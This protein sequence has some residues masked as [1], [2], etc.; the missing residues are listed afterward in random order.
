MKRAT[1][2]TGR[3]LPILTTVALGAFALLLP[4][5]VAAQNTPV[6]GSQNTVTADPPVAHPDEK[7][8]VVQL[9]SGLQFADFNAKTYNYTPP[10]GCSGPWDKVIFKA[11]FS[12]TAGVQYDRTAEVFLGH[13]NIYYGTTAEPG[14]TLAPSWHIERDVTDYSA[15]FKTSQTGEVDLGNLVNSTYTGVISGSATLEF[16]KSKRDHDKDTDDAHRTADALYPLPNGPGGAKGLASSADELAETFT[17][18]TNVERAYLDVITQ[19]Q[20]NDEFWY[21]CAPNDVAGELEDCGN[22]PF[23]EAEISVD[24]QPAGVAPVYPWIYTG[25]IDPF[26]WFP[27]P[28]VQTLNFKPYRVDLTPFAGLLSNGQPHT[29]AVSV[30]NANNYFNATATLL[31]FRDPGEAKITGAVTANTIGAAPVPVITESL[32]TDSSGDITGSV[33]VTSHREFRVSGYVQTSHGRV[34]TD[35][36]QVVNFSSLQNYSINANY[37]QDITQKTSVQSRTITSDHGQIFATLEDFQFPLTLNISEVFNADGSLSI[38]TSSVQHFEVD[39]LE[40]FYASSLDNT[41]S[42]ADTLQ[43]D[44]SFNLIGNTGQKS[45]QKYADIDSRGN[46]YSCKLA[47]QNN[48]LTFISPGCPGQN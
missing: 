43:L 3:T 20:N 5:L 10:V 28:G 17:L 25:G 39:I 27:L 8:C 24:G 34:D 1:I 18:P 30:F 12:V 48:T 2:L 29:I 7:P 9:Y 44:S 11:D 26:L 23:R 38:T 42:S 16:Y 19:S 33:S 37:V 15:L 14:A 31:V 4:G 13:V 40:P 32:Q 21:T 22:T 35:V 6:V 36:H 47:A 41:V 45:S 46:Y